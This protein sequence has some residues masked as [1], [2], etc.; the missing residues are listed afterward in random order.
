M[1]GKLFGKEL[2][3]NL[4]DAWYK[5]FAARRTIPLRWEVLIDSKVFFFRAV[6]DVYIQN[7]INIKFL[8]NIEKIELL[9]IFQKFLSVL[10]WN[11]Y[12][13]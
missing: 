1:L 8:I 5:A 6:W 4:R 7:W 3:Q 2:V 10:I 12:F 13:F 9:G 11:F